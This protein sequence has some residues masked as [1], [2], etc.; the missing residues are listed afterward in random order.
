[1]KATKRYSRRKAI[2]TEKDPYLLKIGPRD[3]AVCTGCGAVYHNKRWTLGKEGEPA[4]AGGAAAKRIKVLCPA[5]Q[6][7]R[8]RFAGGYVTLHGEFLRDHKEEILNLI[9]NK[10]ERARHIN[11]LER[12]I[13][14]NEKAGTI[15]ITTTTDKFAQRLG[16]IL[17][18]AFSGHV[19]YKWSDDI[20][21]ARVIWTR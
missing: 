18:K 13:E 19:E 16:R 9:K 6:K 4:A 20:K 12:I 2:D 1:M 7:I 11:P 21:V 17:N 15:E 3:M 8:D 10:E 14:I 5:C